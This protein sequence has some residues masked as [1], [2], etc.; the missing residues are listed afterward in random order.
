MHKILFLA[1]C[2]AT[3]LA[4]GQAQVK[5]YGTLDKEQAKSNLVKTATVT[6]APNPEYTKL[7][8]GAVIKVWEYDTAG[9]TII[10]QDYIYQSGRVYINTEKNSFQNNKLIYTSSGLGAGQKITIEYTY[11]DQ[12]LLATETHKNGG[13]LEQVLNYTYKKGKLYKLESIFA[14]DSTRNHYKN[15]VEYHSYHLLS[16]LL[17]SIKTEWGKGH[18]KEEFFWYWDNGK[19]KEH[20]IVT[21]KESEKY[22]YEYTDDSKLFKETKVSNENYKTPDHTIEY[23]FYNDGRL[24]ERQNR[25]RIKEEPYKIQF[26]YYPNGLVKQEKYIDFSTGWT[27]FIYQYNYTYYTQP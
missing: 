25:N 2:F 16:G 17:K 9:H 19:I 15:R 22:M 26:S 10:N 8:S 3:A 1:L 11:N 27:A 13:K 7:D 18:K 21:E 20:I 12:G 5:P 23:L 6:I 24:F 14:L 4:H